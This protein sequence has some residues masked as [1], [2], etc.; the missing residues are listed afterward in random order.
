MT[1][2]MKLS[3]KLIG[4]VAAILAL[5]VILGTCS[6]FWITSLGRTMNYTVNVVGKRRR[7]AFDIYSAALRMQSLDR[8][9]MLK[10]IMQQAAGAEEYKRDYRDVVTGVHKAVADYQ[11]LIE[12][13]GTRQ[14][15]EKVRV[16]LDQLTQAH[17]DL[18]HFMDKQ[19][20]DQVQ[21]TADEKVMPRA[22]AVTAQAHQL[23]DLDVSRMQAASDD[24]NSKATTGQWMAV[25]FTLICLSVGGVIIMVVRRITSTLRTLAFTMS[26]GAGQV[27]SAAGQVAT[28]SQ[29][30]AQASS[31]Q[32][33]SLEETS[34][35]GV[36]LAS[37]TKKNVQHTQRASESVLETDRQLKVA[38]ETLEKMV[39]SMQEINGSSKKISRIIRVIDEI[40]F[41]TNILALNAAVEAARAGE[42]GMGFA[43]VADEVRNL[44]QRCAQA[45][46][47]TA[48]L[49]EESI[50]TA[51]EGSEK[52]NRVVAAIEG[53]A[54]QASSVKLLV[55]SVNT[56]SQEQSRS[57]EQIAA[58]VF[59]MQKVTQNTAASAE[60]GAAA[61]EEMTA[62]AESMRGA[63]AELY[64][65]VG[66]SDEG[67]TAFRRSRRGQD[68]YAHD[69]RGREP[70]NGRISMAYRESMNSSSRN[71]EQEFPLHDSEFTKF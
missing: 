59:Q 62:H 47:D 37:M 33:A 21:K 12:D 60:Q 29:A 15:F 18:V 39:G 14:S 46:Q 25:L 13:E 17:D 30:L 19:Q 20:F 24:A 58:A 22:E 61:S 35:S 41:Q 38:N 54:Q 55:E 53:I 26:D 2:R 67:R 56:G 36:S 8:A 4:S 43:V 32:A 44:A 23:V 63:V 6:A 9:I 3:T 66:G 40:A 11:P 10:S 31:E 42:A 68:S 71:A 27:A 28:V 70:R 49:I 64:A 48:G 1:S 45:A 57:I 52:L 65:M 50:Q 16:G 69:T 51:N 34:A 5:A 7:V